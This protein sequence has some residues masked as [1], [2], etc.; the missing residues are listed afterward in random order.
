MIPAAFSLF[1]CLLASPSTPLR[2]FT[3][4]SYRP[5]AKRFRE[6]Q[7]EHVAQRQAAPDGGG[8]PPA[9]LPAPVLDLE[10]EADDAFGTLMAWLHSRIA[11]TR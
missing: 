4:S 5:Y 3:Y 6:V 10:P 8:P 2:S 7:A 9:S 11:A 1:A